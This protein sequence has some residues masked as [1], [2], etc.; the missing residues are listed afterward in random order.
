M[1]A[2]CLPSVV[3]LSR[4]VTFATNQLHEARKRVYIGLE[5]L[6]NCWSS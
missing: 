2:G 3:E 4:L 6:Q 5:K 1:S